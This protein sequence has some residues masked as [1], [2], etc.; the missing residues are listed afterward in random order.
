MEIEINEL[1]K[2]HTL[3]QLAEDEYYVFQSCIVPTTVIHMQWD[4]VQYL[5][6][7]TIVM[8]W[9]QKTEDNPKADNNLHEVGYYL[10]DH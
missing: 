1:L 10:S 7:I 9:I 4:D 6:G 2:I 8:D 5:L 3:K